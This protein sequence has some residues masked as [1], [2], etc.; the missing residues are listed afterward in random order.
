MF[1]HQWLTP[2]FNFADIKAVR[3]RHPLGIRQALWLAIGLTVT[4]IVLGTGA[5]YHY[6]HYHGYRNSQRRR[7]E[8]IAEAYAAQMAPQLIGGLRSQAASLSEELAWHP[9]SCLL[10]VL[11][12][13]QEIVASRGNTPLLQRYLHLAEDAPS[14]AGVGSWHVPAEPERMLPEM[15]LAAVPIAVPNSPEPLGTLIY[16]ARIPGWSALPNAEVLRFFVGLGLISATGLILAFLWLQQRVVAPLARLARESKEQGDP[17]RL[18]AALAECPDEIGEL[19]RTLA[20][21]RS[22]LAEW[23]GKA[24]HL[25][26]CVDDRVAART[27]G[28]LQ[29]LRKVEKKVWTDPLT[30]LGNRRLFDDKFEEIARAQQ[31]AGQDLSII[32]ID[33]DY[34]KTLNDTLGHRAGDELLKFVGELLKQC[35]R[36]QDLAI[37]YGGDE[38]LLILPSVSVADAKV[39]AERVIKMF[40]QQS[41][42]LHVQPRPTMSA[43]IASLF[44]HRPLTPAAFLEQ[45]DRALYDAKTAG[46]CQ[47][48]VYRASRLPI[49]A[50]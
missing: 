45:A 11:S 3:K 21:M 44:E 40:A 46:K 43:G 24:A 41:R 4:S 12:P 9:D 19:A 17:E 37:R 31:E 39:I 15:A 16:A 27:R 25:E 1:A 34:F 26:R 30:R 23:Q 2:A 28:I 5:L 32:M 38:F 20:D 42:M 7:I 22:N 8:A 35:L 49:A 10:A 14:D 33:V 50:Q 36:E 29:D 18:A 6:Q 48:C 47:V 13:T